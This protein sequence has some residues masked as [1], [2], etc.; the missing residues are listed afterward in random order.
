MAPCRTRLGRLFLAE[1]AA[2]LILTWVH[3]LDVPSTRAGHTY[4]RGDCWRAGTLM[5]FR[6]NWRGANTFEI[7]RVINQ[8]A[9][10]LW[11]NAHTA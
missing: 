8:T 3:A 5:M 2:V 10:P 9:D 6:T 1:F 4:G 11:V 7:I